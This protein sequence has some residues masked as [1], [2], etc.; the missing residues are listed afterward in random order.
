MIDFAPYIM[1]SASR[2]GRSD[3][4]SLLPKMSVRRACSHYRHLYGRVSDYTPGCQYSS[5]EAYSITHCLL[6]CKWCRKMYDSVRL[7]KA[8]IL[9]PLLTEVVD[10]PS[11]GTI[12]A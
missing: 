11:L 4:M 7:V 5:I 9:I 6:H 8:N 12:S 2:D 1:I 10:E 3:L